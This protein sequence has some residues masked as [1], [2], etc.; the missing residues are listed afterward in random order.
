MRYRHGHAATKAR[1]REDR[2]QNVG[3]EMDSDTRAPLGV[4]QALFHPAD[5]RSEHKRQRRHYGPA[6]NAEGKVRYLPAIQGQTPVDKRRPEGAGEIES[7]AGD[8]HGD[9]APPRKPA[10]RF[11]HQRHIGRRCAKANEEMRQVKLPKRL[12]HTG[13]EITE[14]QRQNALPPAR[15]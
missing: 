5:V 3:A 11:R 14:Q 13:A 4:G 12:R 10:R 9:T 15:G 1:E 7:A 8:P 6:N 2:R